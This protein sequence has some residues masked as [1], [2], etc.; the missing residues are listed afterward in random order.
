MFCAPQ[1]IGKIPDQ[2]LVQNI[3]HNNVY[4]N[5][6]I[7]ETVND[8]DT[9][10]CGFSEISDGDTC[11]VEYILIT[12]HKNFFFDNH[13]HKRVTQVISAGL[14]EFESGYSHLIYNF[15]SNVSG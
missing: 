9:D 8:S 7:S 3:F 13:M 14:L 5:D 2:V 4:Q 6:K 1:A 15:C 11:R 10:G 12:R